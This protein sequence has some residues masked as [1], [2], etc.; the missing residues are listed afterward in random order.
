MFHPIASKANSLH[1]K[2]HAEPRLPTL[3]TFVLDNSS[4]KSFTRSYN[5]SQDRVK[6]HPGHLLFEPLETLPKFRGRVNLSAQ[7]PLRG[8]VIRTAV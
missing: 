4:Y 5:P 8:R 6:S 1:L 3:N 7:L 2:P